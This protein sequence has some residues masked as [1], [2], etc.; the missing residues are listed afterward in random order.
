M[1]RCGGGREKA[2][3][4]KDKYSLWNTSIKWTDT[5]ECKKL[6]E[7]VLSVGEQVKWKHFIPHVYQSEKLTAFIWPL[8][9]VCGGAVQV[10]VCLYKCWFVHLFC[11]NSFYVE[12]PDISFIYAVKRV[13]LCHFSLA[14]WPHSYTHTH[15]HLHIQTKRRG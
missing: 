2:A 5:C 9:G 13:L 8:F 7:F 12:W 3:Q 10:W 6:S 11:V 14:L 1:K 4:E 15:T